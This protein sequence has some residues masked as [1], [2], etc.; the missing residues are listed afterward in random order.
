MHIL[1]HEPIDKTEVVKKKKC[2]SGSLLYDSVID[3][4]IKILF[5]ASDIPL[6]VI[7][8][9]TEDIDFFSNIAPTFNP[10]LNKRF[11]QKVF[12]FQS[13]KILSKISGFQFKL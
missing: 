8:V 3:D 10:A 7:T 1:V 11:D 13:L 5:V 2:I 12:I 9:F 6:I 4:A